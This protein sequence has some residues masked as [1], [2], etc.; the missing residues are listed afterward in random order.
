MGGQPAG[1]VRVSRG[2]LTG[3]CGE[4]EA[5]LRAAWAGDQSAECSIPASAGHLIFLLQALLPI[6]GKPLPPLKPPTE[7]QA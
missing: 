1:H 7:A 3:L 5:V 4:Y 2:A 6:S